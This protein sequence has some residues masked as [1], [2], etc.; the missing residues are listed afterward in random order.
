MLG[1]RPWGGQEKGRAG[2]E[3]NRN[4]LHTQTCDICETSDCLSIKTGRA[5]W[6]EEV[7]DARVVTETS[8]EG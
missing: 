6:E 2:L 4:R 1:Q 3:V 7:I 5:Y 8:L